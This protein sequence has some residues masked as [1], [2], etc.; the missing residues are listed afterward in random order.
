VAASMNPALRLTQKTEHF[1]KLAVKEAKQFRPVTTAASPDV[2]ELELRHNAEALVAEQE[3]LLSTAVTKA[4]SELADVQAKTQEWTLAAK[5]ELQNDTME[6]VVNAELNK[7]RGA[8]MQASVEAMKFRV[9]YN[10]FRSENAIT[11]TPEY[12]ESRV[13]H[14]ALIAAAAFIESVI[15]AVFFENAQGVLGGWLVALAVALVCMG[16]SVTLGTCFRYKNLAKAQYQ[17]FGWGSLVLFIILVF[18]LNSVFSVFRTE[19]Q[20]VQNP[21]D[22]SQMTEASKVTFLKAKEI[23][24]F[25]LQFE[26]LM[27]FILFGTGV[28]LMIFAFY[29]GYTS[30]DRYP[31]HGEIARKLKSA[32]LEV[33]NLQ[34]NITESIKLTLQECRVNL[35]NLEGAPVKLATKLKQQIVSIEKAERDCQQQMLSIQGAYHKILEAYRSTN[36][37][38]FSADPPSYFSEYPEIAHAAS[39]EIAG[40]LKIGLNSEIQQLTVELDP[41][42]RDLG[43]K[44]ALVTQQQASI[45]NHDLKQ[46]FANIETDA[47]KV[48]GNAADGTTP[49]TGGV[50]V[51]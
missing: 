21:R 13:L 19:Y 7:R 1:K 42:T 9:E 41:L 35:H 2:N 3:A 45:L 44:S 33:M 11:S 49:L 17:L 23:F 8:L 20:K 5:A 4:N 14:Y 18:Y 31:G 24:F 10:A 37:A 6:N 29:K 51:N 26:D 39:S 46:F 22:I 12:P 16:S 38:V 25:N 36:R 30:E 34:H 50:H 40:D 32:E 48:I 27:S 43:Q 47:K 15:N 28:L